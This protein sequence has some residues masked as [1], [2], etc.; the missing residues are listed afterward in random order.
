[1][2]DATT[3][4]IQSGGD[5][6]FLGGKGLRLGELVAMGCVVPKG[7]TVTASVLDRLVTT[8]PLGGKINAALSGLDAADDIACDT[9][10][11]QIE[12]AICS[13]SLPDDIRSDIIAAYDKLCFDTRTLALQVAVR[14]SAVGEDAKDA[15]FARAKT[16]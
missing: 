7:F 14:S 4:E 13:T 11:S 15:S 8:T 3:Y 9:A 16:R 10:A 1:M 2:T 6:S 5:E 12:A